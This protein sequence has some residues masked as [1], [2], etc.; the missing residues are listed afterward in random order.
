MILCAGVSAQ[1]I[2][3]GFENIYLLIY[4]LYNKYILSYQN[5]KLFII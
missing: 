2:I 1:Y 4:L 3:C 5:F